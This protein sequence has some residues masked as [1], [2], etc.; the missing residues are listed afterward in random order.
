MAFYALLLTPIVFIAG[1]AVLVLS[2]NTRLAH[3]DRHLGDLFLDDTPRAAELT[4]HTL[5]RSRLLRRALLSFYVAVTILAAGGVGG[6]VLFEYQDIAAA[7]VIVFTAAAV[8]ATCYGMVKLVRE[9]LI[10]GEIYER[11]LSRAAA[12][13]LPPPQAAADAP[14]KGPELVFPT[15]A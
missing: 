11:H 8:A 15:K 3:L 9:V 7:L 2:V 10:G 13:P 6:A 12:E 1:V 5:R 14:R 4:H